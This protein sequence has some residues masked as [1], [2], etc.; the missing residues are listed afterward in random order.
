VKLART[1]SN[2]IGQNLFIAL[3]VSAI[4]VIASIFGWMRIGEA[5]ILHEG[6]TV[7]VVVNGLRL[8]GYRG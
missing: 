6:S 7:L 3:G 1:A 8:L 2:V 5:V 4:L